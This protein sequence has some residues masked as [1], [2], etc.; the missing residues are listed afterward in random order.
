MQLRRFAATVALV[1]VAGP[2]QA[3]VTPAGTFGSLPPNSF[4]GSGIP[5]NA[6][7]LGAGVGGV[8]MGL[9]ATPR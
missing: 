3:Q 4:G 9:S 1:L 8:V 7:M 5:T 6:V 2:I